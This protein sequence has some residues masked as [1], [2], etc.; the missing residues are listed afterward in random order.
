MTKTSTDEDRALADWAQDG[1]TRPRKSLRGADAAAYGRQLLTD[2]GVD[3]DAVHERAWRGRPPVG[4]ERLA[5]GAR[6][7]RINVS[8]A[9]TTAIQLEQLEAHTGRSRSDIVRSALEQYL[10]QYLE[11]ARETTSIES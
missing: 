1:M 9:T 3:V 11:D 8:I 5:P 2:A 7:P 4:G 10:K 6:S